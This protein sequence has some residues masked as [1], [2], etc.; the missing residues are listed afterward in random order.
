VTQFRQDVANN[1]LPQVSW[2]VAP[3]AYSEHPNHP[4][5]YG[6]WFV[7]QFLDALTANPA[8][9]SKTVLF[10]NYDE[11]GGFF[12][13]MVPPTPP[14]NS[15]LGAST[16][17]TTN[18]LYAGDS[19][20]PA[21]PYGLGM[22]VPMLVVSPWSKGGWVDSQVF[23]HTS[24][25]R[26]LEARFGVTESNITPWR[27]AVTGDLTSAFNFARPTPR[28]RPAQHL[29]L[30]PARSGAPCRLRGGGPHQPAAAGAGNRRAPRPRPALCAAGQRPP[31]GR[32]GPLCA[33]LPQRRQ[34]HRCSRCAAA[35]RRRAALLHGGA[36]PRAQGPVG[37]ALGRCQPLRPVGLRPQRLPAPLPGRVAKSAVR[38]ETSVV[39]TPV[40][41]DE[42]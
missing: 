2:I 15:S 30:F 8:V 22:R 39:Y 24:V 9:W 21:G 36:R 35:P 18:E 40:P 33:G 19:S 37:P 6:A 4:A 7:S 1:T 34:R 29:G 10:I 25:I 12:D 27:R 38:V 41:G 42:A 13:H 20:H 26:F 32:Q 5:D 14:A 3:E 11:E 16:V 28:C 23:D 31:E 17:K